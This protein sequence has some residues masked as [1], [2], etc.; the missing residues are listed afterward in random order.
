MAHHS[1]RKL[2][3]LALLCGLGACSIHPLPSDVTGVKTATIVRKIRCEAQTALLNA[4]IDYVQKRGHPE[5][6]DK[7]SLQALFLTLNKNSISRWRLRKLQDLVRI[8]IVYNFSLEGAETD[9]VTFSSDII[10]PITHGTETLSPSLGNTVKRDNT[11]GFTVSDNFMTLYSLERGHCDFSPTDPT[12]PNY[13]YPI[14]GRIGID[15]MIT[16][17]VELAVTGEAVAPQDL[18]KDP[19]NL[20]APGPPTMVDSIIFTTTISAGLTPKISLSPVGTATQLMDA[21]LAGSV[22][23]VDTH[24]VIVGLALGPPLAGPPAS[25]NPK[26]TALF[27]ST[28][29]KDTGTGEAAAAQAIAQQILRSRVSREIIVQP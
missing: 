8:G 4:A 25:I 3:V 23:R 9:G 29:A 18:G 20:S 27:I 14:V 26:T 15:E 13:E 21:S 5:V 6:V 28:S 1:L 24:Q 19:P 16:T 10:K 22:M 12:G 17:F 11:R 2:F 7:R